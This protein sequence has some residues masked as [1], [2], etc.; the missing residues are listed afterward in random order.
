VY[1]FV[2]GIGLETKVISLVHLI[3]MSTVNAVLVFPVF[4]ST[5]LIL[6]EN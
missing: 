6:T 2:A 4:G 5:T 3:V 1:A